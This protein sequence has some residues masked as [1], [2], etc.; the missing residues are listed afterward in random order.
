MQEIVKFRDVEINVIPS[1]REK[2]MS[3]TQSRKYLLK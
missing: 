2:Y 3:C 1:S